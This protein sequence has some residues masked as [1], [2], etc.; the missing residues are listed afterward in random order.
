MQLFDH[1]DRK[2]H[3]FWNTA[4]VDGRERARKAGVGYFPRGRTLMPDSPMPVGEHAGKVM[5]QVPL[6]YLAWVNAQRWAVRWEDWA[7][8]ADYLSR[9]P[10]PA[11][12]V[13]SVTEDRL[14]FVEPVRP[15]VRC[16]VW[17]FDRMSRLLGEPGAEACLHAFAVGALGLAR[18]WYVE[19]GRGQACGLYQLSPAAFA[20]AV[21]C[22]AVVLSTTAER[23]GLER[24]H[25]AH[26][27][28][29]PCTKQ[30]YTVA[31]AEAELARQNLGFRRH[32]GQR[33][34]TMFTC[35]VCG[36]VHLAYMS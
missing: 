33:D 23:E 14:V 29:Q 34:L 1:D 6:A 11:E 15:A 27:R 21:D 35:E 32:K 20:L 24:R 4:P 7:P 8:V 31:E 30:G 16:A 22:G 5:R 10:L 17:K 28:S 2:R 12:V 13:G 25:F 9:F 3:R 18:G 19:R 26:L 36:F